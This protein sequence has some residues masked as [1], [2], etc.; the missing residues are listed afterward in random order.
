MT[1]E[2]THFCANP[3]VCEADEADLSHILHIEMSI[4]KTRGCPNQHKLPM[5]VH[6]YSLRYSGAGHLICI[7]HVHFF[8]SQRAFP[9]GQVAS[10]RWPGSRLLLSSACG[11][12]TW[13]PATCFE[14]SR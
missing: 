8:H 7:F 4:T 12:A 3:K 2:R 9:G 1:A 6:A 5:A 14:A 10:N 13:P 11:L